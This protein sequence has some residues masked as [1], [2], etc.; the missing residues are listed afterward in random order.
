MLNFMSLVYIDKPNL[1]KPIFF[2]YKNVFHHRIIGDNFPENMTDPVNWP[3]MN[4]W[5]SL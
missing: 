2:F 4:I 3:A 1:V 5:Q